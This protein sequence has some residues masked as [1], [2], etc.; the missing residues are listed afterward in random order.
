MPIYLW[1]FWRKE[2]LFWILLFCAFTLSQP[3]I[4]IK[5]LES[6]WWKSNTV[7]WDIKHMRISLFYKKHFFQL[8][9]TIVEVVENKSLLLVTAKA[10]ELARREDTW[11]IMIT[12]GIPFVC[13]RNIHMQ[14]PGSYL[15]CFRFPALLRPLLRSF[16]ISHV[17]SGQGKF[18]ACKSISDR[19]C[20]IILPCSVRFRDQNLFSLYTEQAPS[21]CITLLSFS[22]NGSQIDIFWTWNHKQSHSLGVA[23]K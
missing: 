13:R 14:L 22:S 17:Y 15:F 5:N 23:F 18:H 7:W 2:L 11:E 8:F 16:R 6:H 9:M 4:N 10:W 19:L 1:L 21:D 20:R 12:S 3:S